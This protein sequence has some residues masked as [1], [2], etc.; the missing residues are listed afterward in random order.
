MEMRTWGGRA[1]RRGLGVPATPPFARTRE[2]K[3]SN[4]QESKFKIQTRRKIKQQFCRQLLP[5][6]PSTVRR[7]CTSPIFCSL[8]S[9][10]R[11][12]AGQSGGCGRSPSSC[13]SRRPGLVIP[14]PDGVRDED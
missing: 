11:G 3:S 8:R 5:A 14:P 9:W 2:P 12:S 6:R 7:L 1:G 10:R 4:T 13:A